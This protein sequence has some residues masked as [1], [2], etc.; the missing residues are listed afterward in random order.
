[1]CYHRAK[2]YY[3][4]RLGNLISY[5]FQFQI[6]YPEIGMQVIKTITKTPIKIKTGGEK[7]NMCQA[8][9]EMIEDG[10]NE[11]RKEAT[12]RI[13]TGLIRDGIL[14][15]E[16]AA[17]RAGMSVEEL[18]INIENAA[19]NSRVEKR[20]KER[21][22]YDEKSMVERGDC[23]SDLPEKFYGL[24]RGWNRRYSR[25]YQQAGLSERT[26]N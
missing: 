22:V 17:N 1:M 26:G 8:V 18:K 2:H 10:R 25:H 12:V 13:L 23:L 14:S 9:D 3:F 19:K 7:T 5:L 15:I 20:T 21:N 6:P 24:E 11:G 4:Y 16:E